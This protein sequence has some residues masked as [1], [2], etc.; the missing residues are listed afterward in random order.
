MMES[1]VRT[2]SR[3]VVDRLT[4]NV[5]QID[6]FA[7]RQLDWVRIVFLFVTPLMDSFS[8]TDIVVRLLVK[9]R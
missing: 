8:L 9:E 7:Y 5:N 4:I 3:P 1:S 6:E 2:I